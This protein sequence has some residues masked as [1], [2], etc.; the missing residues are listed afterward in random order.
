MKK[1]FQNLLALMML[2]S[3]SVNG[4]A[5][6]WDEYDFESDGIRYEI[7]SK[8][9]RTVR[10]VWATVAVQA[11]LVI[12]SKVLHESKAYKVVAIKD[13][14]IPNSDNLLSVEIPS[15]VTDIEEFAFGGCSLMTSVKM[16][17]GVITIKNKAFMFCTSLKSIEIPAT[18]N[19]IE[20]RA[21]SNF[22]ELKNV[23][24]KAL[25]PP[26]GPIEVFDE[27]TYKEGTLYVPVGTKEEYESA[28]P[29]RNFINIVEIDFSSV[30]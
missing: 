30:R 20:E 14:A 21:F 9:K 26:D 27:D 3:F 15:T 12:P 16:S 25:T 5:A 7:I 29:W 24:C 22:G 18:V 1:F 28:D 13:Y 6:V 23:Y 2:L 17:E 10:V 11:N 19:S 8:K 4:V